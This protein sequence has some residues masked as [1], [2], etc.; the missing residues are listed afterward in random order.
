MLQVLFFRLSLLM[1]A[2]ALGGAAIPVEAAQNTIPSSL[3][4]DTQARALWDQI[5]AARADAGLSP[6]TLDST[7]SSLAQERSTDMATHN[8]FGHYDPAGR[9][10]LD[11]MPGLNLSWRLAS[12]TLERN[13]YANCATEAAHGLVTSPPHHA[14]LFDPQYRIGGVGHAVSRDGMHYFAIIV[15]EP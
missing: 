9:S 15:I 7:V 11:M 1:C 12:E 14:I 6:L 10:F 8:Y 4:L 2:I 3:Y 5:A 13:T